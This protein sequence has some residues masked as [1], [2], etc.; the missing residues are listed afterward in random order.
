MAKSVIV[1]FNILL[2]LILGLFQKEPVII[3]H[4]LPT[5]LTPGSE[6]IV[7]VEL[8]KSDISGFAKYQVTVAEG[9]TI[10]PIENVGSSFT[11][12]NQKGKF[13][14]MALPSSKKFILKY[15]IKADDTL[16]GLFTVSSRFSYIYESERKNFDL[17]DQEITIGEGEIIATTLPKDTEPALNVTASANLLRTIVPTGINQWKVDLEITKSNLQGFARIEEN[18]PQ[19]Y[20]AIDLKSSSSVFVSED[21]KVKYI[22]YDIPKNET[23]HVTYKLLPVI[24]VD[25]IEP[26]IT[27]TF[28]YMNNDQEESLAIYNGDS[29]FTISEDLAE[30]KDTSN[31]DVSTLKTDPEQE[32]EMA[33]SN[34]PVVVPINVS[35]NISQSEVASVAESEEISND[36]ASDS[37]LASKSAI[38]SNI[39]NVPKPETGISYR[40]QIAAGH[41]NLKDDDFK[42]LYGFSE[43][44]KL[45]SID[46]WLKYT[47]GSHSQ[48]K[49]ARNERSRIIEEYDKFQGPFVTAYNEGQRISVQEALMVTNQQWFQ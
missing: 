17:P 31:A 44:L 7:T 24:A 20:T 4:D 5:S 33:E 38:N 22:W 47:T 46:G 43:D 36:K 18:I 21:D 13:I 29:P 34:I 37:I 16:N 6:A 23:V 45:E 10:E 32:V 48:Y 14:W 27:G 30:V 11:F 35:N 26:V 42:K 39:V 41:S 19:G 9:L 12:N 25:G 49:I 40:V 15:K 3:T 8:N 28:T 1:G 2:I